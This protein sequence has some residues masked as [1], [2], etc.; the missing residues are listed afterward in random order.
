MP[1]YQPENLRYLHALAHRNGYTLIED[2]RELDIRPFVERRDLNSNKMAI[3][4]AELIKQTGMPGP[5]A[6]LSSPHRLVPGNPSYA[7]PQ[8]ID[9]VSASISQSK[10]VV[11]LPTPSLVETTG[12]DTH[13]ISAYGCRLIT[14]DAELTLSFFDSPGFKAIGY[15]SN[16]QFIMHVLIG[17]GPL[18]SPD[19]WANI[20]AMRKNRFRFQLFR[21][22]QP[23]QDYGLL[24]NTFY[25]DINA[26]NAS[27]DQTVAESPYGYQV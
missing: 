20:D 8:L 26:D 13:P 4:I 6:E 7:L 1:E 21:S 10:L 12:N 9:M 19:I 27:V 23:S 2:Q 25:L 15:L 18:K 16:S 17:G 5:R 22:T 11:I 14:A 24:Y 3:G